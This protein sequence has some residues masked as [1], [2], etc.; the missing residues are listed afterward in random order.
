MPLEFDPHLVLSRPL[1]ANLA[2]VT[3][4]GAPRNA[5]V[6]FTWEVGALWMLSDAASSSAARV[7]ATPEVAVE[8]VDYDNERG[9]LRHVGMRGRAT[10]EPM[11]AALFRRLL[12]RYLGPEDQQNQWFVDNVARVDDPDGRLIRLS[13]SSI[14]TNDVSFFRTGPA[15]ATTPAV[16]AD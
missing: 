2:T 14:F 4:D 6:W 15:L 5:P 11:N 7:A 16:G 8:I 3:A 1:M 13:P 10:V 12:R 9:L